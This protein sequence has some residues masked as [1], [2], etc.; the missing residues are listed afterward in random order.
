MLIPKFVAAPHHHRGNGLRYFEQINELRAELIFA[1]EGHHEILYNRLSV[2]RDESW[3]GPQPIDYIGL[4]WSRR[5]RMELLMLGKEVVG[6][7]WIERISKTDVYLEM[8]C[9]KR[10]YRNRG[11]GTML[12]RHVMRKYMTT[13]DTQFRLA[14]HGMNAAAFHVYAKLGFVMSSI[15]MSA[16]SASMLRGS[17]V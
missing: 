6:L 11:Y 8:F 1:A 13:P 14:V 10:E 15:T 4:G 2:P 17:T 3:N 9:I 7:A 5:D 12:L 16:T